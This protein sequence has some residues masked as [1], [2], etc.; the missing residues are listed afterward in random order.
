MAL[1]D[2]SEDDDFFDQGFAQEGVVSVWLSTHDFKDSDPRIDTLQD[3]C[4]VGY[5]RLDEQDNNHCDFQL[6]SAAA[7][8]ADLSFSASYGDAVIAAA[9]QKGITQAY[10]VT[11][12]HNFAYDPARVT[13]PIARDPVFIGVF[14]YSVD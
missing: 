1:R 5:Y 13:R 2:Y 11:V 8:L 6:T 10:G 14:S 4:G 9:A 12:Q 7:L 3:L